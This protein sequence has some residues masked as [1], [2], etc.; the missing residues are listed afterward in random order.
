MSSRTPS[1]RAE[2]LKAYLGMRV[3]RHLY[4]ICVLLCLTDLSKI[5]E[6]LSQNYYKSVAM[7][8]S[9]VVKVV[10]RKV[11]AKGRRD[12][13]RQGGRQTHRKTDKQNEW[14]D[15]Y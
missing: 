10:I 11:G 2:V 1:V 9:G 7:M 6:R 15:E 14:V 5:S 3:L 8:V 4:S 13:D 12:Q